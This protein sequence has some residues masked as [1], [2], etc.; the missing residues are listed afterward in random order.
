MTTDRRRFVQSLAGTAALAAMSNGL[1]AQPAWPAKPVK[2]I[3]GFPA[4][5]LTDAL[6]RAYGD[7]LGQKLGQPFLVD[8]KPGASGMLA[9]AEVAKAAPDGHTFWFTIT[10][11]TNHNRVFYKKMPYDPDKDFVHVSGF[12]AGHLPLA[13]NASSPIKS[14]KDLVEMGKKQRITIGN[15]SPGSLPH[16]VAQQLGK[17]YGID[18]EPIPYR[19]EAPMWLDLASG[20]IT[21]AM[22]SM[23][24]INP[25]IQSGKV[26]PIAVPTRVRS[27]LLPDVPTFDEQGFKEQVFNIEGWIGMFG[28]AGVPREIV[29]RISALCQEA[30]DTPRVKAINKNFGLN[31]KPWTAEQFEK[32]DR[33][34]KPNWIALAK[35]LNV[36]LD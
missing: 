26:R 21:A 20:Q 5:G 4:G 17:L 2:V 9:G 14:M 30:A 33:E 24:A 28:P 34:N 31:D 10:G 25:H 8:N 18:V 11:S 29:Q 13:V 15:Y 1:W 22:G 16:M 23:L 32:L 36:T 12:H 3:V 27:P 35:E 7:Y 6:A 19:G